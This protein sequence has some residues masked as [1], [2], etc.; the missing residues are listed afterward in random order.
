MGLLS[1]EVVLQMRGLAG[2]LTDAPRNFAFITW[3]R[4]RQ[5]CCMHVMYVSSLGPDVH[6]VMIVKICK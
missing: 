5:V 2:F 6:L 1:S 3:I 4:I